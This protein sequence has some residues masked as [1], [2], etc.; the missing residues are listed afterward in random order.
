MN[1]FFMVSWWGDL[2]LVP[3]VLGR[4]VAAVVFPAWFRTRG[5]LVVGW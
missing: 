4:G 3:V 2:G 5:G 1:I